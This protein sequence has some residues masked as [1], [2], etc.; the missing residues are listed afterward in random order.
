[1]KHIQLGIILALTLAPASMPVRAAGAVE[2]H[3]NQVCRVASGHELLLT[4][5]TG[6]E[7]RGYCFPWMWLGL[8]SRRKPVK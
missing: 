5:A 3:W 7:L 4:T 6:E 8:A 2:A 1:M